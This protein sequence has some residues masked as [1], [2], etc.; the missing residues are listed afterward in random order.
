MTQL[1][2]L[3]IEKQNQCQHEKVID[4]GAIHLFKLL[5]TLSELR[6]YNLYISGSRIQE[7]LVCRKLLLQESDKKKLKELANMS[8]SLMRLYNPSDKIT[9]SIG[10]LAKSVVFL[11]MNEPKASDSAEVS[12]FKLT[13]PQVTMADVILNEATTKSIEE[14][15]I[16]MVYSKT[17]YETWEYRKIKPYGKATILSFF[18]PPGTGKTRTAQAL[19]ADLGKPF[20]DVNLADLES[21]F[22]SQTSK[23]IAEAFQVATKENALIFFDEADTVLGKRLGTVTQGIDAEI[24]MSRSTMLKELER[25]EGVC[26]FATN[27]EGNIDR[28][29]VRRI[30]YHIPFSLPDTSTLRRL[31]EYILLPTIPLNEPR[32]EVIDRLVDESEGLSGSDLATVVVLAFPKSVMLDKENP[33]LHLQHLL[34]AVDFI[35]RSNRTVGVRTKVNEIREQYGLNGNSEN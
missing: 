11:N 25:F 28:A 17:L 3:S 8:K 19:A 9:I 1:E 22:M 14:A 6:E 29:F 15:K 21:K 35:K 16:N 4:A 10:E 31:W 7:C 5:P 24:N 12:F 27:F 23:N 2:R 30:A 18:G 32:E 33:I 26:V 34:E 13:E 20:I